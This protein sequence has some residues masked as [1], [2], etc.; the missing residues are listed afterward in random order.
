MILVKKKIVQIF[1]DGSLN[2]NYT[3]IKKLKKVKLYNKDHLNFSLNQ[4]NT[5]SMLD[6]KDFE[7]FKTKYL[8]F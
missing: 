3:I 4:K 6:S 8:K 7:N 5:T 2:F 1:S